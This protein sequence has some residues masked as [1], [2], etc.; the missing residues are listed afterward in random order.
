VTDPRWAALRTLTA[1][2]IGLQRTGASVATRDHLAFQAAH[3]LA[4]DAVRGRLDLDALAQDVQA[5]TGL[6]T[7]RLACACPDGATHLARPDLGRRL[8]QGSAALLD[9]VAGTCDAVFLLAGGLSAQAVAR[10]AAPLLAR[11][12]PHLAGWRI[13][14]ACLAEHGRVALGDAVARHLGAR[15]AVVLI[16]ERPGLSSPDSLGAY[17]TWEPDTGRTDAQRNCLSNIRPEGL[18]V[19]EA[20][21]RLLWLMREARARRLTGVALKDESD[22]VTLPGWDA[23]HGAP[24][25]AAAG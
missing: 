24:D 20:A 23:V 18:P 13:G 11:L 25:G 22:R 10:H 7:L 3:A 5:A 21:R 12:L 1:A 6:A 8:D 2:R 4:R 16:G 15:L 9:G 19:D 14:P 17:L